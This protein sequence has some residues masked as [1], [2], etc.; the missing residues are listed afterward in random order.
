MPYSNKHMYA[1]T[2][3]NVINR[4]NPKDLSVMSAENL[5]DHLKVRTNIAHPQ[6][7]ADGSWINMGLHINKDKK[8]VDQSRVD[9]VTNYSKQRLELLNRIVEDSA[10][11]GKSQ[12]LSDDSDDD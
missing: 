1:M 11:V 6:I 4:I 10:T 7:L 8:L 2:E 5:S 12:Q 9:A 3:L